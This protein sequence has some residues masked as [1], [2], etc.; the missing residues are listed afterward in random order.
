[1]TDNKQQIPEPELRET[2][3]RREFN[4]LRTDIDIDDFIYE[5]PDSQ[6]DQS[7]AILSESFCRETFGGRKSTHLHGGTVGS[8]KRMTIS[9]GGG[10]VEQL[11]IST[12]IHEWTQATDLKIP[13]HVNN[14]S[15]GI[16]YLT[17]TDLAPGFEMLKLW[18]LYWKVG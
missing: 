16:L 11:I 1:M 5:Q 10:R 3:E 9:H 15:A 18:T 14:T 7:L 4:N 2:H 8:N 12:Y 13:S 6:T 17:I